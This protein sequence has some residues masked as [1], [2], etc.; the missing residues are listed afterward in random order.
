M[1]LK[2]FTENKAKVKA[3]AKAKVA[4]AEL[5]KDKIKAGEFAWVTFDGR[6]RGTIDWQR[7]GNSLSSSH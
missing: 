6:W 1:R 4:K 2:I 7:E 5:R 3:K